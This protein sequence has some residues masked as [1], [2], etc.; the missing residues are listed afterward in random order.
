MSS[1]V[2]SRIK[3]FH[4]SLDF[5]INKYRIVN[6]KISNIKYDGASDEF[7]LQSIS[8]KSMNKDTATNITSLLCFKN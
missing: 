7:F 2:L 5:K 8:N 1:S 4:L 3:C 6:F